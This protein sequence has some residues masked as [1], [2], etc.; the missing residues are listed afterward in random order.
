MLEGHKHS[1]PSNIDVTHRDYCA[2]PFVGNKD[3]EA[4]RR[5]QHL[6]VQSG[7]REGLNAG[8]SDS[9]NIHTHDFLPLLTHL[10]PQGQGLSAAQP[11]EVQPSAIRYPPN[12]PISCPWV[13]LTVCVP[14]ACVTY[15]IKG[16]RIEILNSLRTFIS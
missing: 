7:Q 12:S 14:A 4:H 5:C 15:A 11:L 9:R 2:V 16:L 8:L 13:P 10:S 3:A 1:D 6:M